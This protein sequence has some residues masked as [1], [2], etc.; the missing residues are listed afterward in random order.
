RNLQSKIGLVAARGR[1]MIKHTLLSIDGIGP[2]LAA[3][4]IAEIGDIS[5]FPNHGA[6]AKF[7]GLWW[8]QHQSGNFKAEETRLA[9]SGNKYLR[10]YLVEAANSLRI[11]NPDFKAYYAKKYS[12]VT[13]HQ[14]KRALVL[15]ARKLVRVIF[16][17]LRSRKYPLQKLW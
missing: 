7:A 1:A 16:S 9:K 11:H 17:L 4:L 12:E 6:L 13:K 8:K 5:L 3:G 2:V 14:H 10:Y 15:S